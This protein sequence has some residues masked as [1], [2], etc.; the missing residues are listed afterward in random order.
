[1]DETFLKS[2]FKT[3]RL[4]HKNEMHEECNGNRTTQPKKTITIV[5]TTQ[6]VSC[7]TK[8]FHPAECFL[9]A[10]P[11]SH[12]GR[13]PDMKNLITRVFPAQVN[14]GYFTPI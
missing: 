10:H 7:F 9:R 3:L 8:G 14:S 2:E 6:G 11:G 12:T 1:M 5:P 13:M 4:M